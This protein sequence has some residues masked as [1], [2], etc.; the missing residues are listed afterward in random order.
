MLIYSYIN[1]RK[2]WKN[3]KLCE[4]TP[5]CGRRVS[6]QFLVFPISTRVDI[7][8]YQH[9]KCFIF[10][11]CEVVRTAISQKHRIFHYLKRY[12]QNLMFRVKTLRLEE[13]K[14][15]DKR[16]SLETSNSLFISFHV[17]P[18]FCHR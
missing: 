16:S 6:T 11:K 1:T 13:N 8:V 5:L 10:L 18:M 9:G 3:S 7:S 2:N 15:L 12:D 17:D 4:N 14:L